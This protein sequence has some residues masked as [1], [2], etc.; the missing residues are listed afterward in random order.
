MSPLMSTGPHR[1]Q[2]RPAG[3]GT[4]L[5]DPAVRAFLRHHGQGDAAEG[6][7][8]AAVFDAF[9]SD[10]E[11]A[12]GQAWKGVLMPIVE[13][14]AT[15]P[16]PTAPP[17]IPSLGTELLELQE[18]TST[19]QLVE[20][21][22]RG[23]KEDRSPSRGRWQTAQLAHLN[24]EDLE[25]ARGSWR[26]AFRRRG[27]PVVDALEAALPPSAILRGTY[28]SVGAISATVAL[29]DLE[30]LLTDDAV[31]SIVS[32]APADG[33]ITLGAG[34]NYNVGDG[35]VHGE[36]LADLLQTAAFYKDG[37]TGEGQLLALIEP[38]ADLIW[39]E[40]PG[41]EDRNGLIRHENWWYHRNDWEERP[42]GD[43]DNHA[44]ASASVLIGDITQGQ[45][46][47]AGWTGSDRAMRSGTGRRT[48]SIGVDVYHAY[49]LERAVEFF[50]DPNSAEPL[51]VSAS[52]G[53][54][55]GSCDGNYSHSV[56]A[57]DLYEAGILMIAG[58]GNEGYDTP[59][60][61]VR[62]PGDAI[63]VFTVGGYELPE[64][65]GADYTVPWTNSDPYQPGTSRGGELVTDWITPVVPAGDYYAGRGRTIVDAAAP[66]EI[67]HPYRHRVCEPGDGNPATALFHRDLPNAIC[68]KDGIF[69]GTSAATPAVAGAVAVWHEWHESVYGSL[70]GNPGA[71][72]ANLLLM[73]D[74][75][76]EEVNPGDY[77]VNAAG[78][79]SIWGAGRF[80][81]R[82]WDDTGLDNPAGWTVGSVCVPHGKS[83]SIPL[84]EMN[85]DVDII[86]IV[87][88]VYDPDH[89]EYSG[90]LHDLVDLSLVRW[91]GAWSEVLLTDDS[92]DNKKRVYAE[93][94]FAPQ[95]HGIRL[96]GRHV[97]TRAFQGCQDKEIRVHYG[98]LHEDTDQEP[99]E[100]LELI[101]PED[102]DAR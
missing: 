30:S 86:K 1:V 85:D 25:A 57:N 5:R 71:L 16:L 53:W 44:T 4:P 12:P 68:N 69:N 60:C 97:D 55:R 17:R 43:T 45:F 19:T 9:W 31:Q 74:R 79:D 29:G 22:I 54:R 59:D 35:A 91:G 95:V 58:A 63:G 73:G 77:M 96:S 78:Y 52:Y 81:L 38:H 83:V 61:T 70:K 89:D 28:P 72:F 18:E 26:Q 67:T 42:D 90:R 64:G 101:R 8:R 102:L 20:V 62:S 6:L 56:L 10:S 13:P 49:Q 41:F 88:Y 92:S 7:S 99:E 84:V 40:H 47:Q 11:D 23:W 100:G 66:A 46:D 48:R 21:F 39:R 34:W 50:A 80:H 3:A 37:F 76:K 93:G 33:D 94:P 15:A 2:R 82:R 87:A 75:R 65:S 32:D 27:E 36:E 98:W 24:G 51:V 14:F